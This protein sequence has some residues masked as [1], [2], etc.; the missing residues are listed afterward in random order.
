MLI[1][2]FFCVEKQNDMSII[3]QKHFPLH[4]IIAYYSFWFLEADYIWL[5]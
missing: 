1:M 4:H 5:G 2:I 3:R